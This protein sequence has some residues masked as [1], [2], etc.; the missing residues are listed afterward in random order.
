MTCRT[1]SGRALALATS[2]FEASDRE[3]RSVPADIRLARVPTS[4]CVGPGVGAE[5][6]T[7]RRSPLLTDWDQT[8]RYVFSSGE[9]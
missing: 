8:A 2:D 5:L 4:T 1:R 7:R 6:S 3:L 9:C